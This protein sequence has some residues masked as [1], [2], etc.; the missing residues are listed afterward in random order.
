MV[1]AAIDLFEE[2]MAQSFPEGEQEPMDQLRCFF[3]RRAALVR[4]HPDVMRLAYSDRLVEVA[5]REGTQ[6][7][8]QM[9]QRSLGFVRKCLQEGQ[10]QGVVTR[11]VPI[12][13]LVWA[14]IGVLRGAAGATAPRKVGRAKSTPDAAWRGVE[15]LFRVRDDTNT[16]GA[17]RPTGGKTIA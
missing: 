7:V 17:Q 8:E 1:A 3:L 12:D 6:K 11:E 14:I 9:V 10:Q 15:A 13:V 16:K 5:G 2:R 4:K